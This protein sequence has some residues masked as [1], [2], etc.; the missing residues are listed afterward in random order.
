M[1]SYPTLPSLL[2]G[3]AFLLEEDCFATVCQLASQ[4]KAD[5][6]DVFWRADPLH[7][8]FAIVLEPESVSGKACEIFP[9]CVD[10][11]GN[12]FWRIGP[13]QGRHYL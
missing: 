4:K 8:E 1:S 12:C 9:V 3:H 2:N 6:G 5:A 13:A 7:V 11:L 10:A